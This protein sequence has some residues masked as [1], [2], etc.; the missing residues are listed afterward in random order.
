M[1]AGGLPGEPRATLQFVAPLDF[2]LS[3]TR[4]EH[5]AWCAGGYGV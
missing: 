1:I 5:A 3:Y 2:D 4:P